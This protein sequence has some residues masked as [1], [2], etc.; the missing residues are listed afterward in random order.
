M[1]FMRWEALPTGVTTLAEIL[2]R[3]GL[4]TATSVDTPYYLQDG[5]NYDVGFQTLLLELHV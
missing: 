5:M 1:S 3:P 2:A 4:H